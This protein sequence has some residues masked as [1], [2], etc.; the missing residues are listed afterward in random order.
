MNRK[1]NVPAFEPVT[2]N[3]KCGPFYRNITVAQAIKLYAAAIA[4]EIAERD[5]GKY[6]KFVSGKNKEE[7]GMDIEKA[8]EILEKQKLFTPIGQAAFVALEA[9]KKQVP[10]KVI[11]ESWNASKCPTCGE[12]LS[13]NMGDGY[14]KDYE[15][16]ER[17]P[18]VECAQR[19][20]WGDGQ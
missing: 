6:I 5:E 2:E 13:E 18:N 4:I 8:I 17:C 1:Y 9:L 7:Y 14:Y 3:K 12:V 11:K 16:L 10:R 20:D 19:L 15:Y